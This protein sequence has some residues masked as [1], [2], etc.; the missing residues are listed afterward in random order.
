MAKKRLDP[1]VY[2]LAAAQVVDTADHYGNYTCCAVG[3]C[4]PENSGEYR[5]AYREMFR[6]DDELEINGY[7]DSWWNGVFSERNRNARSIALLL[8]AE[9]V[10]DG[11]I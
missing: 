5:H 7:G 9:M 4:E 8:M 11:A 10:N 3:R 2:V 6:P 1:N